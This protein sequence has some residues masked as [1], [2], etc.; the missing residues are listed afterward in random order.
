[1]YFPAT[2]GQQSFQVLCDLVS[3]ADLYKGGYKGGGHVAQI[4][5]GQP[6]IKGGTHPV[7]STLTV[8]AAAVRKWYT[9]LLF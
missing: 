9:A 4:G 2:H 8:H 1:M 7:L 6:V 3:V 5:A